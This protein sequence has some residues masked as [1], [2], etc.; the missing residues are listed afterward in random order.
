MIIST[1]IRKVSSGSI[2]LE[3]EE[4]GWEKIYDF[5]FKTEIQRKKNMISQF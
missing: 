4:T 2:E 1:L 3:H 5:V